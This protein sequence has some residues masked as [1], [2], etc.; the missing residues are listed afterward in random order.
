[1]INLDYTSNEEE[2]GKKIG[3]DLQ[4]GKITLPL[5]FTLQHCDQKERRLLSK[6][7]LS[8]ILLPKRPFSEWWR[9][10]N[11]IMGSNILGKRRKRYVERAK[12]YLHLFPDSK[13]KEALYALADYVLERKTIKDFIQMAS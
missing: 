6:R 12:D 8:L 4:D 5:I 13:E 11:D 9:S 1:M 10:S 3:I 2:F 7:P